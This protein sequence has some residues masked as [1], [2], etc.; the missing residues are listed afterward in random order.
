MRLRE[1]SFG[2]VFIEKAS[3]CSNV[4]GMP[5][6]NIEVAWRW[7]ERKVDACANV[8]QY[9]GLRPRQEW[10]DRKA[11][12]GSHG[13]IVAGD[14]HSEALEGR[15]GVVGLTLAESIYWMHSISKLETI[16]DERSPILEH[17]AILTVLECNRIEE[18]TWDEGDVF[19]SAH[20]LLEAGRITSLDGMSW[21]F[22]S[23]A[24][25]PEARVAVPQGRVAEP[26]DLASCFQK[27]GV[28]CTVDS[29]TRTQNTV[30]M[31]TEEALLRVDVLQST[32]H[33]S[34]SVK[35][36]GPTHDEID[37]PG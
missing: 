15:H 26:S 9:L 17:N 35:V 25:Q 13:N 21:R 27:L 36:R 10:N 11:K 6:S 8:G 33:F 7:N 24:Q 34:F 19:A 16:L 4:D 32:S 31:P 37:H 20:V 5:M 23:L 1:S 12:E 18:P 22:V 3:H 30:G 29:E 14:A 2:L 28:E